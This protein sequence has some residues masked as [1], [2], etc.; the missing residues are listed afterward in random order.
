MSLV[1]LR[2][3]AAYVL[4]ALLWLHVPAVAAIALV[5]RNPLGGPLAIAVFLAASGSLAARIAPGA[6]AA[7][8]LIAAALTGMPMLFVHAG[9]GVWQID[10]H[11]YFFA[12]LAMLAAFVDWRPIALCAALTA[13]HHLV[14]AFAMPM[15]VFPDQAGVAALPRVALHAAIVVAEF[16]VLLWMTRTVRRAFGEAESEMRRSAAALAAVEEMRSALE[17]ASAA[18]DG[19][20]HEAR[21]ALAARERSELSARHEEQRMLETRRFADERDALVRSLASSLEREVGGVVGDLAVAANG[22]LLS[23]RPGRSQNGRA[24]RSRRSSR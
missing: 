6:T 10:Y 14:M 17:A 2:V 3:R 5:N 24:A 16:F 8:L 12:V 20:L 7:R 18:K 4:G 15:S 22:M 19:A 1:S 9:M 11:M 23:V 13:V 21:E